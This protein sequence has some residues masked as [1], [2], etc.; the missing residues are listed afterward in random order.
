MSRILIDET[1]YLINCSLLKNHS[2]SGVTFSLKNYY[3]VI[4]NPN[5]TNM[6]NNYCMPG[7]LELAAIPPIRNKLALNICEAI[8]GIRS[9]GPMGYP[10]IS[11]NSMI[12][13][14]DPVALDRVALQFLVDNGL[15]QSSVTRAKY[16]QA[17]SGDPYNLGISD[18]AKIDLLSHECTPLSVEKK[19][20]S[21]RAPKV[22]HLEQNY[23]NPFNNKT[24]IGFTLFRDSH[25]NLSVYNIKGEKKATLVDR[26]MPA[27]H[28]RTI[29]EAGL[30][31]E[32][33]GTYIV[34][35]CGK[36]DRQIK[37]IQLLK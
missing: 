6:H 19:P 9:G 10:Q 15:A 27:G 20:A 30:N 31:A 32:S 33:S 29:W 1:D 11:P 14:R 24:I 2:F 34:Q 5:C 12:F 26:N 21:I 16:I 8:Y 7:L 4:N 13:S 3:G 36:N 35:L 17:A 18:P 22:F 25:V 23:P 28:H 37:K